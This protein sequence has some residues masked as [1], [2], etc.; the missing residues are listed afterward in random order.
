MAAKKTSA[1]VVSGDLSPSEI[2]AQVS[3]L[4]KKY[5]HMAQEDASA[6]SGV[7][8]GIPT[9]SSDNLSFAV[10]NGDVIGF[11]RNDR[12]PGQELPVVVLAHAF[13]NAFMPERYVKGKP[14]TVECSAVAERSENLAPP[15]TWP[16]EHKGADSCQLCP[17]NAFGTGKDGQGKACR[18]SDCLIVLPLHNVDPASFTDKWIEKQP[19]MRMFVPPTSM[20]AWAKYAET[21]V[22]EKKGAGVPLHA[23]VTLAVVQPSDKYK[24]ELAFSAASV[25]DEK[26]VDALTKRRDEARELAL[27]PPVYQA[28]K[29]GPAASKATAGGRKRVAPK[30]R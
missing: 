26:T 20:R 4:R 14:V 25:L 24:Q 13:H 28:P 12:R 7:G 15:A 22:D 21:I 16:A 23:V 11:P 6:A 1:L 29:K 27:K 5:G 10:R 3:K 17:K 18:N 19:L 2:K 9:I 30:R 8:E